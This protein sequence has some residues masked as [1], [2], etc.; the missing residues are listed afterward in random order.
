MPKEQDSKEP[1]PQEVKAQ[2]EPQVALSAVQDMI[3]KAVTAAM[4]SRIHQHT[5]IG[6][7]VQAELSGRSREEGTLVVS[8]LDETKAYTEWAFNDGTI[9]KDF[10]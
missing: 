10:K 8:K 7:V 5:P 2:S 3:S 9:R 1:Q 6:Q 4:A